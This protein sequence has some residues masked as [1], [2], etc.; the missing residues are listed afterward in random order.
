M[1]EYEVKLENFSSGG[2]RRGDP[3]R[4]FKIIQ[5]SWNLV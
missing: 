3:C 2:T 1:K 4:F 5:S